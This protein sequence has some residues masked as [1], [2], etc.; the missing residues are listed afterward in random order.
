MALEVHEKEVEGI[1]ILELHGRLVAGSESGDFRR[2]I[3]QLLSTGHKSIILDMK[4][5]GFIDSTGLGTLVVAHTQLQKAGGSVKLLNVSKRHIQ[6]LVLTKLSTVFEMFD[7]EQS[8][9]NSFF[10]D[11]E[12]K[13]FDILEFVKEQEGEKQ[14]SDEEPVSAQPA[15]GSKANG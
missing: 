4:H 7:D 13:P 9:I 15:S 10:P 2:E 11:R 1:V 5:L 12:Q 6:L 8:A 14:D 3:T